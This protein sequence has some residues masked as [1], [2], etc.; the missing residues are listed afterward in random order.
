MLKKGFKPQPIIVPDQTPEQVKLKKYHDLLMCKMLLFD[1][2]HIARNLRKM[3][4]M[5]IGGAKE[6]LSKESFKIMLENEFQGF[7]TEYEIEYLLLYLPLLE[8]EKGSLSD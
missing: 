7:L 1:E 3:Y 8:I 2:V 6:V 5:Y 4:N